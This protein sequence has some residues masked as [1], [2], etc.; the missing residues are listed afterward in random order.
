MLN[1]S[2]CDYYSAEKGK[3]VCQFA[4]HLFIKNPADLKNYPC[5]DMSYD[6]YLSKQDKKNVIEI[7]A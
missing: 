7:V 5:E 6:E 1:C 4:D 2:Y 3:K